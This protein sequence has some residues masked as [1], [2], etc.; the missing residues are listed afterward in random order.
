MGR[1][2]RGSEGSATWHLEGESLNRVEQAL[3]KPQECFSRFH[4]LRGDVGERGSFTSVLDHS[5]HCAAR[6]EGLESGMPAW[7][8]LHVF[9][10][11]DLKQ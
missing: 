4:A 6:L 7:V 11:S 1:A 8:Y 10:L 3:L 2:R 9:A 5:H